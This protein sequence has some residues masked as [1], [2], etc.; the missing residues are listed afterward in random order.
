MRRGGK[1]SLR[2][3]DSRAPRTRVPRLETVGEDLVGDLPPDVLEEAEGDCAGA[4]MAS[5]EPSTPMSRSSQTASTRIV[6]GEL[7]SCDQTSTVA[8]RVPPIC[9]AMRSVAPTRDSR[10]VSNI[11]LSNC[12]HWFMMEHSSCDLNFTAISILAPDLR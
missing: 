11:C 4:W 12:S 5:A 1:P 7:M 8:S 3:A 10:A 2:P 6:T 9:A